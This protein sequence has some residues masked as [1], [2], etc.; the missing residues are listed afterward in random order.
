MEMLQIFEQILWTIGLCLVGE[1]IWFSAAGFNGI[2]RADIKT[3]EIKFVAQIPT[4]DKLGELNFSNVINVNGYLYFCPFFADC[5]CEYDVKKNSVQI[6][7]QDQISQPKVNG[8][9]Y[10]C[11][12]IYMFCAEIDRIIIFNLK[13]KEFSNIKLDFDIVDNGERIANIININEHIYFAF[14]NKIIGIDKY[15][16]K[17]SEDNVVKSV[18]EGAITTLAYDGES[19]WMLCGK[20]ML[21]SWNRVDGK[22]QGYRIPEIGNAKKSI[23]DGKTL[24]ILYP[25]VNK[26]LIMDLVDKKIKIVYISQF[27]YQNGKP[28]FFWP[29][30]HNNKEGLFLY[31]FK[32]HKII[33]IDKDGKMD[34]VQL[35]MDC[36]EQFLKGYMS[37]VYR[38]HS[39]VFCE[40]TR[41]LKSLYLFLK[42]LVWENEEDSVLVKEEVEV[43][44]KIYEEI[45]YLLN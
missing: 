30:V 4:C 39:P 19:V 41:Y 25:D 33:H 1:D 45:K 8:A 38:L 16:Q 40:N 2:F 34:S 13:T 17:V 23:I 22:E 20:T 21:I 26:I 31:T 10:C 42:C 27:G 18:K 28:S 32:E 37:P 44:S 12:R 6:Y 5:M 29:F 35:Y 24:Y 15:T 9:V 11:D 7:Y 43:G 3:G 14:N 36:L